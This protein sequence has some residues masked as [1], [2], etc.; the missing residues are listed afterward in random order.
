M[1]N[2]LCLFM[3]GCDRSGTTLLQSL[4]NSHPA[5]LVTYEMGV[6]YPFKDIH[7]REGGPSMIKFAIKRGL[8]DEEL[9]SQVLEEYRGGKYQSFANLMAKLFR[10]RAYKDGKNIWSDKKPDYTGDID[11]LASLF[12]NSRFVNIIRDPRAVSSSWART[13]WG[14]MTTY[15]AAQ[16]WKK[17]VNEA[18]DSLIKLDKTRY[19]NILFEDLISDP[20][21]VLERICRLV[22]QEYDPVMLDPLNRKKLVLSKRLNKL[23]PNRNKPIDSN[24]VEKWKDVSRFRLSHI[25][26][27]CREDMLELGYEP[28]TATR[29]SVPIFWKAFY[30]LENKIFRYYRRR[31]K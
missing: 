15:H 6:I 7:E 18:H 27:V 17:R 16:A 13:G 23:H 10:M 3:L 29:K 12:P 9:A 20:Q 26:T 22:E 30:R 19:E 2:D 14:P 5:I 28:I 31:G 8:V 11:E 4:L 1:P 24:I 21:T 25:E